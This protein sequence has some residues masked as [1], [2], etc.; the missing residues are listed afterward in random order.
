MAIYMVAMVS[1]DCDGCSLLSGDDAIAQ[2][3]HVC[4]EASVR[5]SH[6][7]ILLVSDTKNII[8]IHLHRARMGTRGLGPMC[9][10]S[11]HT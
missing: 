4:R 9:G 7:V 1:S 2:I 3:D 10:G 6:L 8:K 5:R 11:L